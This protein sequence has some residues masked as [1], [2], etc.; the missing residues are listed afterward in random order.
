M[1]SDSVADSDL[2]G[3]RC[4]I[5][6][7]M[8]GLM[9]A[10]AALVEECLSHGCCYFVIDLPEPRRYVQGLTRPDC[11]LWLE[12]VSNASQGNSCQANRL[13][14][15]DER[16]LARLGWHAPDRRSPNW[17]RELDVRR[18]PAALAAELLVR[19]LAEVHGTKAGTPITVVIGRAVGR[20]D[21]RRA[22]RHHYSSGF[23]PSS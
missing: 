18:G 7:T 4:L 1:R 20:P 2:P 22:A 17:Y 11:R 5:A 19:T 12:S 6:P 23:S 21:R 15:D 14:A 8:V 9:S 13:D 10:I 16:E 3:G